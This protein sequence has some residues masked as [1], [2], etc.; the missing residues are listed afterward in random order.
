MRRLAL[1]TIILGLFISSAGKCTETDQY[2]T[3]FYKIEDSTEIFDNL[4]NKVIKII[5]DNWEG[6]RNDHRFVELV[7]NS[8]DDTQMEVWVKNNPQVDSMTILR[9]NIYDNTNLLDS[10]IISWVKK[11]TSFSLS[12]VQMGPDKITHFMGVGSV[13]YRVAEIRYSHLSPEDRQKKAIK[14]GISTEKRKWGGW[15]TRIFSNAD[16]VSNYEGLL[17]L[18]GLFQDNIVN[19]K[20][21]II[22]WENNR[23]HIQ[24]KFTFSDHINE[25]WNEAKNPNS[26]GFPMKYDIKRVL[27]S[28]CDTEFYKKNPQHF[29]AI[30]DETLKE[31]YSHLG[32]KDTKQFHMNYVCAKKSEDDKK[33]ES[34]NSQD[35]I[36]IVTPFPVVELLAQPLIDTDNH[37]FFKFKDSRLPL[38]KR[39]I[40]K[41]RV[42]FSIIQDW[43]RKYL[44]NMENHDMS[45]GEA[46]VDDYIARNGLRNLETKTWSRQLD[47]DHLQTCITIVLPMDEYT[48]TKKTRKSLKAQIRS[49]STKNLL[50]QN[51]ELTKRYII[52]IYDQPM[53]SIEGYMEFD[54]LDAYIFRTTP[55]KC[56]WL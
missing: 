56:K 55:K 10:P 26:F 20:K 46:S 19:G 9:G 28:Y 7:T 34:E 27:R 17:F 8:F 3:M 21:A 35:S 45:N 49:C 30:Q 2:T 24:R 44:K 38:C 12:N 33:D 1:I 39:K 18:L 29:M 42:E 37:S 48:K 11:S 50:N 36:P 47:K 14:Y 32:F 31:K 40:K 6:P 53:F 4:V 25:Y 23:P 41:A 22:R 16:L 52:S 43:Y 51:V 54:D 5:A 13:Y 15:T